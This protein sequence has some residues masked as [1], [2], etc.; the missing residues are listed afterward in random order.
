ML[1]ILLIVVVFVGF[2]PTFDY[3]PHVIPNEQID[4]ILNNFALEEP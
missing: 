3:N 1:I 2:F 4:N